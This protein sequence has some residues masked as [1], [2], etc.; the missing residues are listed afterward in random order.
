MP[1]SA[2][3]TFAVVLSTFRSLFSLPS[4]VHFVILAVGW[5]LAADPSPG[6]CV[7]EAL[8]AA[9]VSGRLP[10]QPFHRFLSR[11]VWYPDQLGQRLFGLLG[12][13]LAAAFVEVALDDTVC[14][15]RGIRVFGASMHV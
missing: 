15:H 2:L 8:I 7:T 13:L 1:T 3:A 5:I 12:P 11:A 6:G 9:R 4:F 14:E 10:W